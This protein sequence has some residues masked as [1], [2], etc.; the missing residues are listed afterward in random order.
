MSSFRSNVVHLR[1]Y[2]FV[3]MRKMLTPT[4]HRASCTLDM[5]GTA[6]SWTM[7]ARER[8]KLKDIFRIGEFILWTE[9][10]YLNT[11]IRTAWFLTRLYKFREMRADAESWEIL[12]NGSIFFIPFEL[13]FL[14]FAI[15]PK[16]CRKHFRT[17]GLSA[18]WRIGKYK[19]EG[20][21][22]K[23]REYFGRRVR[24]RIDR[25]RTLSI[26]MLKMNGADFPFQITASEYEAED[27][28]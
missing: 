27:R 11:K 6:D 12:E 8:N 23:Y 7:F 18:P 10:E 2:Y 22:C 28:I 4:V 5:T 16:I 20:I 21:R 9:M 14:S 15:K 17:R 3:E 13:W 24:P 19:I 26:V 1:T 25:A